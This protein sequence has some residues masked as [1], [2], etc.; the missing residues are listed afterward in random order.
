MESGGGTGRKA[1]NAEAS[2]YHGIVEGSERG[3]RARPAKKRDGDAESRGVSEEGERTVGVWEGGDDI[4][5]TALL[6]Q[7]CSDKGRTVGFV[8]ARNAEQIVR[9][10][11]FDVR[12]WDVVEELE[13]AVTEE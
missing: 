13:G 4:E 7:D 8:A 3:T 11:I 2:V 1:T 9:V 5:A 10:K 6:L 12:R